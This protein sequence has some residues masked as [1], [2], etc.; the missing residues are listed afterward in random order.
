[1]KK[2]ILSVVCA[3]VVAC[4]TSAQVRMGI[5][6]NM[7]FPVGDLSTGVGVGVGGAISGLYDFNSHFSAGL[8]TGFLNFAETD[9][10]GLTLSAIPVV[11]VGKYYFSESKF[12]PYVG[13]DFGLYFLK[14][15]MN[16]SYN[17][18]SFGTYH[19]SMSG[20]E[21]ELGMA[22]TVGFEYFLSDKVA[23]DVN[24]KYTN[25]FTSDSSIAYMGLNIG[26]IC[27]L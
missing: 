17:F 10:Q 15:K 5:N 16:G 2:L 20:T 1:M 6:L 3:V 22:P 18:G 12:K 9:N 24:A 25:I 7:G 21:T 8:Q 19:V 27:K 4:T 11:A 14:A 26:F 13:T 23:L